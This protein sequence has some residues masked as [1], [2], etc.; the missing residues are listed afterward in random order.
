MASGPPGIDT[1]YD[2]EGLRLLR[3]DKR[4]TRS[5]EQLRLGVRVLDLAISYIPE[6]HV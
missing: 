5:L 1:I 2:E 4:I 3:R 6:L